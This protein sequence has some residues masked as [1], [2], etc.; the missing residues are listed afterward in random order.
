MPSPSIVVLKQAASV[1]NQVQ[2]SA[3]ELNALA[4][5]VDFGVQSLSQVIIQFSNSAQRSIGNTD[6][7][8]RLFFILFKRP[9]DLLTF[10][11]GMSLMA[12]GT[13]LDDI[14]DIGLQYGSSLLSN[15]LNLSN[16][17]FVYRLAS[18]VYEDPNGITGLSFFLDG[19]VT[20]LNNSMTS[21]AAILSMAAQFDSTNVI[22]HNWIETSIDYIA[23]TGKPPSQTELLAGQKLPQLSLFRQLFAVNQSSAYGSFPFFSFNSNK[24]TISGDFTNA[25]NIDL[26]GGPSNLGG[27]SNF[28]IFIS[29]DDGLTE[30]SQFYQS[31]ILK[32][33]STINATGLT[34]L[35]SFSINTGPV[36]MN[37]TAPN[38][39]S[40]LKSGGGNN[41]FLGGNS[42]D[43]LIAGV[44][45]DS[46]N[47]GLGN[48]TLYAG[49]NTS[50]TGGPGNDTFVLP[51]FVG[52]RSSI[53]I[54]DFGNGSDVLSLALV[55]GNQGVPRPVTPIIGSS[56]RGN[57]FINTA[58]AVDQAVFLVYNTGQWV[59]TP[60]NTSFG[61]RTPAQI[62]SLFTQTPVSPPP[63]GVTAG[64]GAPVVFNKTPLFGQTYFVEVYDP[65]PTNGS[66]AFSGVEIWM[67]NNLSPLTIVDVSECTLIGQMLPYGNL[68]NTL[69]AS[70]ATVI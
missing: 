14:C 50:M 69:S 24:V 67:I 63:A 48:D 34:S 3:D 4:S 41:T 31:S 62:A 33:V 29:Q 7:L 30:S 19:L 11:A 47:G 45:V 22:Y 70:G 39:P 18:L 68:W 57:G 5:N 49:L 42:D 61:F 46:L 37:V 1:F 21:R 56:V 26:S 6:E 23:A 66:N 40:T 17:D 13:S 43:V 54:N 55:V 53:V 59:D 65:P 2:P 60:G 38:V 8:A 27:Q 20:K 44:G 12:G 9:P 28:R 64:N 25:L 35:K 36:G 52:G 32:T 51:A 10:Q 16:R 58:S 15:S